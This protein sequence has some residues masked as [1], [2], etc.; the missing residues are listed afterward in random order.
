MSEMA[1]GKWGESFL[2]SGLP[3]EHLASVM[4]RSADWDCHSQFEYSRLNRDKAEAWF[5]VDLVANS[6]FANKSAQLSILAE[7]KYHDPS[8]YWFFLPHQSQGRWR[9]DDRVLNCAPYQ[10]LSKPRADTLL[11]MAPL[12]SGAIVVSEDGTKQD[13]AAYTAIQQVV[14]GFVPCA[15]AWAF[16]YNIDYTNVLEPR[17]QLDFQPRITALVPMVVTNASLYRLKPEVTDLDL[18]RKASGPSA[19]ADNVD[20]TWCYHD[21]SATLAD[22]NA[23]AIRRHTRRMPELVYR[24]PNVEDAMWDFVH[25]PN[26]VAVVNIRCLPDALQLISDGF[27]GLDMVNV[28]TI[29]APRRRGRKRPR[30]RRPTAG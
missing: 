8:R 29:L 11:Q 24:F 12:S 14:N 18:I 28:R 17:D 19:V 4:F 3:L 7:C 27:L 2:K 16:G 22:Q 13:N 23:A 30:R 5:E 10:T 20:W 1:T 21:V 26:W 15:L 25:R 9:F 6:P